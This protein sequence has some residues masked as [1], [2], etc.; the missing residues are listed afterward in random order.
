MSIAEQ[1]TA[2]RAAARPWQ[3]PSQETRVTGETL[4]E[5]AA[6]VWLTGRLAGA[7]ENRRLARYVRAN[8]EKAYGRQ[9]RSL[10][11]FFDGMRLADIR[12]DHIRRY[13][14]ARI[15]GDAPFIRK[16]RPHE[17]PRSSPVKPAQVNQEIGM[18]IRLLRWA[19]IWNEDTADLY[20]PLLEEDSEM[21]RALTPEEQMRWIETA[22]SHP[23][24][25]LIYCYSVL[26]FDT[27]MS[28]NELRSLRLGDINL[29]SRIVTIP[30][31]GAKV[32]PRQRDI[33]IAGSEA[34]WA[35][36]QL[37]QRA[38]ELGSSEHFHY[39]FPF[40][41]HRF[42]W[43]PEKPAAMQFLKR[44]WEEVREASGLGWFRPYDTRHTAI[45]RMAEG[46][47]SL[48]VIMKRAGHITP[49]MTDHYTHLSQARQTQAVRTAQQLMRAEP[50]R[51]RAS[52]QESAGA[53]LLAHPLVQAEIERQVALA[54]RES[55][56]V[57]SSLP[58]AVPHGRV[59]M[60]PT[61]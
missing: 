26:A 13:Q 30:P 37:V 16:V 58:P 2:L 17:D 15:A 45:T 27:C 21:P 51:G 28:T 36:E 4:F 9:I 61:Q 20:Q 10:R 46:G 1:D 24:W 55:G 47:A 53:D 54:L 49:R 29:R 56:A 43:Y 32:R 7:R 57:V 23:R 34:F 3:M 5:H 39:L 60:F 41:D 50:M 31:E 40:R 48:S 11:L 35:L 52:W 59:I 25:K 38:R 19:R 22:N 33:E 8:T 18:L 6:E 12:L 44:L 14:V 42:K